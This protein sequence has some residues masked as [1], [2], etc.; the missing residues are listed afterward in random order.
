MSIAGFS[1][2]FWWQ[3]HL[4]SKQS[5]HSLFNSIIAFHS[6]AKRIIRQMLSDVIN[7]F[8]SFYNIW[9]GGGLE[10][11]SVQNVHEIHVY[12]SDNSNNSKMFYILFPNSINTS[13]WTKF[14][15]KPNPI[16]PPHSHFPSWK[17]TIWHLRLSWEN[18]CGC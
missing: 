2:Y 12:S 9:Q 6:L 7:E 10:W 11:L 3:I 8:E 4:F 18:L 14:Q 16:P 13:L 15:L 1:D 5:V 17:P